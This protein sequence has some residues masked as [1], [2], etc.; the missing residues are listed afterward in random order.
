MAPRPLLLR[1]N[2]IDTTLANRFRS[3]S[4]S[5]EES[6]FPL[7]VRRQ[8][9][10]PQTCHLLGR[11][12]ALSSAK[13]PPEESHIGPGN[14]K[15]GR[16]E[17]RREVIMKKA[18]SALTKV[19]EHPKLGRV[20]LLVTSGTLFCL[21][22]GRCA[23]QLPSECYPQQSSAAC[24][25]ALD[26]KHREWE[27]NHERDA[28]IERKAREDRLKLKE[29]EA[30]LEASLAASA[31]GDLIKYESDCLL[32]LA[33]QDPD[34]AKLPCDI[35]DSAYRTLNDY[36]GLARFQKHQCHADLHFLG[37]YDA[38]QS[39]LHLGMW[40]DKDFFDPKRKRFFMYGSSD[41]V[42]P[43][44]NVSE[45]LAILGRKCV[46]TGYLCD[47]LGHIFE[48][49]LPQF[50]GKYNKILGHSLYYPTKSWAVAPDPARAL[51]FYEFLC[52]QTEKCE[53]VEAVAPSVSPEQLASATES[54]IREGL[55]PKTQVL[56][57]SSLGSEV[58]IKAPY[59]NWEAAQNAENKDMDAIHPSGLGYPS[60][61]LYMVPTQDC[62]IQAIKRSGSE[63]PGK[64][65]DY[66]PPQWE[67]RENTQ[68]VL[69]CLPLSGKALHALIDSYG[70]SSTE[71]CSGS[72]NE[73]CRHSVH[74][75]LWQIQAVAEKKYSTA[76]N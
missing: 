17:V 73:L 47:E 36:E 19:T 7:E 37:C 44:Q 20:L 66:V 2:G 55:L 27:R 6:L 46:L 45:G 18:L 39:Y 30:S 57:L 13:F 11:L 42:G 70:L 65:P 59:L 64:R 29:E 31:R 52:P 54:L 58:K 21:M 67:A 43:V 15:D 41:R 49:G 62:D 14:A 35:A 3:P 75:L 5:C 50:K 10:A 26:A 4:F 56:L 61:A 23:A 51:A 24:Q 48:A 8:S 25:S 28:E 72:R 76:T 68:L 33:N 1:S 32:N 38:A 22:P 71:A 74:T 60:I 12:L 16:A 9:A 69:A 63:P 34:R 53:A 40:V